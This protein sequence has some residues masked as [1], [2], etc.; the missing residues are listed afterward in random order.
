MSAGKKME[1]ERY[2]WQKRTA[3]IHIHVLLIRSKVVRYII[4]TDKVLET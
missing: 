2:A 3:P 1:R 4:S